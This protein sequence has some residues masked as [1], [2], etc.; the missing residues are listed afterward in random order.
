MTIITTRHSADMRLGAAIEALNRGDLVTARREVEPLVAGAQVRIEA[1]LVLAIATRLLGDYSVSE[2]AADKVLAADS[3]NLRGMMVK[4]DCR[5]A[6]NDP[7][8]ARSFYQAVIAA[9][10]VASNPPQ[11]IVDELPRITAYCQN[12]VSDYQAYL[13]DYISSAGVPRSGRFQQSLDLLFGTKQL[14]LQQPTVFYFPGLPQIQFY[15]RSAFPWLADLEM[16]TEAI[17]DELLTLLETEQ[18]FTPYVVDEKNRPHGDFHGL[19]GNPDWSAL[20]LYKDGAPVAA[21]VARAPRTFAAMQAAPLCYCA[22]RTPGVM[23]SLL[24]GGTRIPAHNGMLNTRLICHLPLIVPPGCALRVGNEVR[25]WKLGETLIFD[26]SIEHEAWNDSDQDR[27][28]LL[29]D[30]WRPELSLEER[31]AVTTIFEAIDS[32]GTGV[33]Q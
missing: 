29:F 9:A 14:F 11:D 24:R 31:A 19:N 13:E 6:A 12:T 3:G 27:V 20:H 26:D 15:E 28:I 33:G 22:K 1:W 30:I 23:F 4:G 25:E 2:T 18:G 32:Y 10:R 7:R 16:A 21:N 17:R 8:A 5:A